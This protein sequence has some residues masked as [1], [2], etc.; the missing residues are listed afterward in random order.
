MADMYGTSY[1]TVQ[2]ITPSDTTTYA[3]IRMLIVDAVGTLVVKDVGG[4]TVT[5]AAVVV[6]QQ[7]PGQIVQVMATGT[8]AAVVGL[9]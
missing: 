8:T 3:W 6:G 5:F 4:N 9:G 7:I 2:R 1:S